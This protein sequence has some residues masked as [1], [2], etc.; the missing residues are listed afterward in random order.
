MP[1]A[2]HM[3]SILITGFF[4]ALGRED[5]GEAPT[6]RVSLLTRP[7]DTGGEGEGW[8]EV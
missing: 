6:A 7:S 1:F 5:Y 8:R 4:S 2:T 3:I